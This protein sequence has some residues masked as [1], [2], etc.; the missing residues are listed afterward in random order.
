MGKRKYMP[1]LGKH[2]LPKLKGRVLWA[3]ENKV[4]G[5]SGT[6]SPVDATPGNLED[7]LWALDYYGDT[8]LL[9]QVK[10][11][12]SRCQLYI[13]MTH[14]GQSYGVTRNGYLLRQDVLGQL[15]V[16]MI[17]WRRVLLEQW[18]TAQLV[19]LDGELMP[20]SALGAGLIERA[21]VDAS[22][23][24]R[25][26]IAAAANTGFNGVLEELYAIAEPLQNLDKQEIIAKHGHHIWRIVSAMRGY[27]NTPLADE[28][29]ELDLYDQELS[30]Y[31][32]TEP[33]YYIPFNVWKVILRDG[34]EYVLAN[35]HY[36]ATHLFGLHHVDLSVGAAAEDL[37]TFYNR[38]LAEGFEGI[39]IKPH[40]VQPD[41]APHLK[42]RGADYLRLIYGHDYLRPHKYQT[43]IDSKRIG[44]KLK[45]S[46]RQWQRL[47]TML[48]IPYTDLNKDNPAYLALLLDHYLDTIDKDGRL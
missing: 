45:K 2:V 25:A 36:A 9:A 30:R 20:W 40:V 44:W 41:Q 23:G 39:V 11:M 27:D 42:A 13:N 33:P 48:Q 32:S 5:I 16:S 24:L 17:H 1:F 46:I 43:L 21:F 22:A 10:H 26:S 12:G 7:P 37:L 8:P 47:Q 3:A 31:T 35:Q 6:M 14:P 15:A 34:T 18:P 19:I 38:V 4:A 29:T 28:L